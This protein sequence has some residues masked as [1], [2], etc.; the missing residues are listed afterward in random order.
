M[1][2]SGEKA[3]LGAVLVLGPEL[4][5]FPNSVTWAFY[6]CSGRVFLFFGF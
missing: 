3:I 5:A 2:G 4:G 6:F 1:G